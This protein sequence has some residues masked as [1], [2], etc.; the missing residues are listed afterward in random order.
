[1]PGVLE[2]PNSSVID[3]NRGPLNFPTV[4]DSSMPIIEPKSPESTEKLTAQVPRSATPAAETFRRYPQRIR[5][6]P[7]RLDL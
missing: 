4:G 5:T 3:D 2:I 7:K 6:A 1:M